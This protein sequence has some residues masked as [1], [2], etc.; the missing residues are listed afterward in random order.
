[1]TASFTGLGYLAKR[2]LLAAITFIGVTLLVFVLTQLAPGD[3]VDLLLQDSSENLNLQELQAARQ[4]IMRERGL[5]RPTAVQY[6][7]WLWDLMRLRLGRSMADGKPVSQKLGERIPYTLLLNCAAIA[8]VFGISLPLGVA[9][10]VHKGGK[11]DRLVCFLLDL[12]Y[13]AP[14]FWTALLL[15][16]L[17]AVKLGWLPLGGPERLEIAEQGGIALWLDRAWHLILPASLLAY[18]SLAFFVRF[19][20]S[21]VIDSLKKQFTTT[22]EAL[23]LP[24]GRLLRKMVLPYSFVALIPLAGALLGRLLAGSVVLEAL[25]SWPGIGQLFAEAVRARDYQVIQALAALSAAMVLV[26]NLLADAA[27]AIADPRVSFGRVNK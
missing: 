7:S 25:F 8:I 16:Y 20:R 17:L 9:L 3:P 21:T 26:A 22:G 23:G 27:L 15:Q 10:A 5:D 11:I 18:G 2:L 6:G 24:R 1:L 13:A 4:E 14:Y 19:V 12:L